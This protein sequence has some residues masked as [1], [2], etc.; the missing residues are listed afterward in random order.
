MLVTV[1]IGSAESYED[2][3]ILNLEGVSGDLISGTILP[4]S[5]KN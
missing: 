5:W 2:W 1:E 3:W 4:F